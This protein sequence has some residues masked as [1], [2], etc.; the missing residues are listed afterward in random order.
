[1]TKRIDDPSQSRFDRL[2]SF[3]QGASDKSQCI[4]YSLRSK[5]HLSEV[6]AMKLSSYF[7]D[8]DVHFGGSIFVLRTEYL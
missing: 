5:I 2:G 6:D 4:P 7:L 3:I 8:I 1:M